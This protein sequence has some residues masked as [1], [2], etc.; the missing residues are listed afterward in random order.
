MHFKPHK[1]ADEERW[2]GATAHFLDKMSIFVETGL[3]EAKLLKASVKV[4]A[5]HYIGYDTGFYSVFVREVSHKVESTII[6]NL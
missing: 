2:K 4:T 1:S 3:M 6:F 5:P